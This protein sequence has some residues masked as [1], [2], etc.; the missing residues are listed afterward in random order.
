MGWLVR[1]CRL[2]LR[3]SGSVCLLLVCLLV[4]LSF[5]LLSLGCRQSPRNRPY[6]HCPSLS[7]W[8][9]LTDPRF[10]P[11]AGGAVPGSGHP[12]AAPWCF[13]S[14]YLWLPLIFLLL[15]RFNKPPDL[16]VVSL[17][18]PVQVTKTQHKVTR[19][20]GSRIDADRHLGW[21]LGL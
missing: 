16:V 8:L 9:S 21:W 10:P 20:Q 7:A 6:H 14:C 17:C 1:T 4:L 2:C 15:G 3:S 19:S 13:I 11:G 5:L 18:R 12:Q